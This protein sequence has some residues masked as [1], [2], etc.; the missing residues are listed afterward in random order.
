MGR[1]CCPGL[2]CGRPQGALDGPPMCPYRPTFL[3]CFAPANALAVL[4]VAEHSVLFFAGMVHH[5]EVNKD[6][7]VHKGEAINFA[8][9][10]PPPP[11]PSG[12]TRCGTWG[13]P[14]QPGEAP[15]A[16]VLG[17]RPSAVGGIVRC[18][19]CA[20]VRVCL[21]LRQIRTISHEIRTHLVRILCLQMSVASVRNEKFLWG[22]YEICTKFV[23]E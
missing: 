23:Q 21:H 11:P 17:P 3:S 5:L 9:S 19:S 8:I 18:A 2:V 10:A 14:P 6:G 20:I 16:R 1:G 12:P 15:S 4:E 22:S 7:T 13:T